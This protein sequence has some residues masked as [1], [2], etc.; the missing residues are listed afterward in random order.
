MRA[1]VT[2]AQRV[3]R[4]TELFEGYRVA[5]QSVRDC[6]LIEVEVRDTRGELLHRT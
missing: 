4:C 6:I 3:A 2:T 5:T 1:R